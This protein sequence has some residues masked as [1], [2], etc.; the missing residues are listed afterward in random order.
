MTKTLTRADIAAA[1]NRKLGFS[2]SEAADL[3]DSVLTE[4]GAGIK[5]SGLVKLSGFG[6]FLVHNKK[7]RVGRN[8]KTKQVAKISARKSASFHASQMLK[9]SL[10]G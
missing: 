6:N 3:L 10:N 8:P 1:I 5:N 2:Q 9:K 7:E 4:I